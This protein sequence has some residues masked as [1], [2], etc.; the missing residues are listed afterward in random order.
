MVKGPFNPELADEEIALYHYHSKS[1]EE[2]K[3]RCSR[4]RATVS[5]KEADTHLACQ[6]DEKILKN[7]QKVP[8]EIKDDAPWQLLKECVPRYTNKFVTSSS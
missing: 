2:Y 3:G 7:L 1:L 4:G 6:P 5:R 8:E